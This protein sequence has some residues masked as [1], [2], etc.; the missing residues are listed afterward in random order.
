MQE[1][2]VVSLATYPIKGLSDLQH[3]SVEIE[4]GQGFPGD[5]MFAFAKAES[6]FNPDN[7]EPMPK[8]RFIVLLQ[9]AGLAGLKTTFDSRSR[10]LEIQKQVGAIST[11]DMADTVDRAKASDFLT[12]RLG[13]T[14]A[15]KPIFASA[16]PHRFT[17]VSVISKRM[18][19]AISFVNLASVKSFGDT[20][21]TEIDARR[22]RANI[23][24]DGWDPFVELQL[25][26]GE[27]SIGDVH[28]KVLKR[29]QRCAATEVNPVTAERDLRLPYLLRKNYGHMDM[30]IYLEAQDNGEISLGSPVTI[31]NSP[32]TG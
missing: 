31:S 20:I 26:G 10:K 18:M 4:N 8:D 14:S 12:Q 16:S 24:I 3:Q 5:R 15:A 23:V 22:F 13:L 27:L 19:N 11:F 1:G 29:T 2:K 32:L 6:G 21:S 30:G 9:H 28:F 25:V 17:D 7:P